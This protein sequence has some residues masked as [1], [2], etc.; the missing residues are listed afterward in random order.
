MLPGSR[1]PSP[2]NFED[3]KPDDK[4]ISIPG[5]DCEILVKDGETLTTSKL[6][7]ISRDELAATD[8]ILQH[9]IA[10]GI[11]RRSK[12][13]RAVPSFFVRDPPSEGRNDGMR[14][15]R[16]V[17]DYRPLNSNI[18]KNSY[19][20]PLIRPALD[21]LSRTKKIIILDAKSGYD[22]VPAKEEHIPLTAWNCPPPRN[23]GNLQP[24]WTHQLCHP[25]HSPFR[26]QSRLHHQSQQ[27]GRTLGLER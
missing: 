22:L 10:I 19:P 11:T 2:S 9:E 7:A 5:Y 6:Y 24:H 18:I 20:I 25:S 16:L 27:E 8:K 3:I 15:V 26:R 4:P 1:K 14:Q 23:V 17:K 13:P 21:K 12:A